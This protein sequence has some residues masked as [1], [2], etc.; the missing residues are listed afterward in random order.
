MIG[1]GWIVAYTSLIYATIPFARSWLN[2]LREVLG[3]SF[4]LW[5]NVFLALFGVILV[6]FLGTTRALSRNQWITLIAIG[7]A[8]SL[9]VS[10]M[11]IPE[12]RIHLLEYA[13]LGYLLV[14]AFR[15]RY[16]NIL[17]YHRALGLVF[18]IGI[19]DELI[20]GAL[21]NR[22]FDL[23]DILFNTLGGAIGIVMAA[24]IVPSTEKMDRIEGLKPAGRD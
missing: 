10:E 11:E 21:P 1:W 14:W 23:R 6:T 22:F 12:E 18:L 20:Q 4:S 24:S 19:G 8:L 17:L 3:S 7:L 2:F 5:V 15:S 9:F 13:G 16:Q